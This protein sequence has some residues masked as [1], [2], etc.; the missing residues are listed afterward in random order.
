MSGKLRGWVASRVLVLCCGVALSIGSGVSVRAQQPSSSARAARP[1]KAATAKTAARPAKT[2]PRPKLV[3]LL[4]VDQMRGD[5]VDKFRGQWTG[6]LKR[7]LDEGAWFRQAAYPYAATETC[8]GHATISTGAF[9]SSHGMIAN[10]WWDR[11]SQKMVTCTADPQ[12]KNMSYAGYE[13]VA[14]T[15]G[16]SA[17]RMELP[18]FAEELKFQTGGATRIMTF[19]LKA[20]AAIT[21]A[22]HDKGNAVTWFDPANGGWETSNAYGMNTAVAA[23]V[24]DHPVKEDAGKTWEL[25]LPRSSYLYGEKTPG[26]AAPRGWELSF[27]HAFRPANADGSVDETFYGQ[28]Q[29]SPFSDAYLTEIAESAVSGMDVWNTGETDFLGISY[30]ALDYVGHAFGPRSLE[31]QDVLVRLDRDLGELFA[32]LDKRVGRGGYVVALSA[33]HGVVP[34][35]EDMQSTGVDAGVLHLPELQERM[36]KALEPFG[37][38]KPAIARI[39]EGNVYFAPGMYEK[40][41]ADPK[42]LRAVEDAALAEPGV[43]AV[44]TTEEVQNRPA[45]H[46]PT[47]EAMAD[48][49]FAGRSGDLFVVNKPYWLMDSTPLGKAR[50]YGTGHGTPHNYDQHVPI[51]LMG[52]GIRPG[53]YLREVTPA[54]ISPTFAVL[55]GITLASRDGHAL[56]EALVTPSAPRAKGVPISGSPGP[57][58][59]T[60]P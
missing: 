56:A 57:F 34:V 16:D 37:L 19:S 50:S 29:S 27:P 1:Q 10:A 40:L 39:G 11:E 36:E 53:E 35:P 17:W 33:D 2:A 9:P 6:G 23:Y 55:C 25:S 20:R 58:G 28:W 24:K 12:A 7:M 15:G 44:Y 13:G 8:V 38:S 26:A 52:Y 60:K 14:A 46:N 3:V 22:G 48:S 21:M 45:T 49:Y 43:A 47:M 30:S 5:Y 18:S 32:A 4:V 51:L 31:V 54:D 41:K 42:A 59:E